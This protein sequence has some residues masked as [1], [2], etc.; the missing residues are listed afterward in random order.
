MFDNLEEIEQKYEELTNKI[1]DPEEIKNQQSWTKMMKERA[2]IE[3]VVLKYREY[4]KT[5]KEYEEAK[6]LVEESSQDKEMQ[7]LAEQEMLEKKELLLCAFLHICIDQAH[8]K[9]CQTKAFRLSILLVLVLLTL[10]KV[11]SELITAFLHVFHCSVLGV[12]V[13]HIYLR[14]R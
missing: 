1:S 14:Y 3:E 10:R 5:K 2:E 6:T 4:K 13:I 8:Y 11:Q 7:E 12:F 9:L